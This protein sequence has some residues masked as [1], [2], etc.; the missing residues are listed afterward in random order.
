MSRPVR[1]PGKKRSSYGYR[2]P[3]L[4]LT[5]MRLMVAALILAVGGWLIL[6]RSLPFAVT[7]TATALW[8]SPSHPAP[9]IVMARQLREQLFRSLAKSQASNTTQAS[10]ATPSKVGQPTP[11]E[12]A[13]QD[14]LKA[15]ITALAKRVLASEPLNAEAYRIL[16]EVADDPNEARRLMKK[17]VARSRRESIAVFWLLNDSTTKKNEVTSALD[18]ADMLLRSRPQLTRYVVGYMAHIAER[19]TAGFEQLVSRLGSD[20]PWR[21]SVLRALPRAVKDPETPLRVIKGL[22]KLNSPVEPDHYG[23]YVQHLIEQKRIPRAYATWLQLQTPEQLK[24]VR[25]INNGGF[26]RDISNGPFGWQISRSQN[27]LTAFEPHASRADSRSFRIVFGRGRVKLAGPRQLVVLAPGTYKL[28][29]EFI[30]KIEAQRGLK[31]EIRCASR[32]SLGASE[33]I[34]DTYKD[35]TQ[36]EFTFVVP[37]GKDCLGQIV[38]LIHTSRSASEEFISGEIWFDDIRI[39]PKQD[40]KRSLPRK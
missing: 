38:R 8:L 28:S 3:R 39:A 35:W 26:D 20:P 24:A 6:S 21:S 5:P 16:G 25:L 13:E 36:F 37:A 23:P 22:E 18:Y 40:A 30:G 11:D 15:R 32:K 19:D 34:A 10:I 17:A 4:H 29:G 33:P 1:R 31:W 7:D 9:Q 12:K 27:A 14:R 2:W